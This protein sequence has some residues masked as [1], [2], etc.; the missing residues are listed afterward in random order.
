MGISKE[1]C[2][3]I[4]VDNTLEIKHFDICSIESIGSGIYFC[5]AVT[6]ANAKEVKKTFNNIQILNVVFDKENELATKASKEGID[7]LTF[8]YK[9][10]ELNVEGYQYVLALKEKIV[11]AQN[12][13]KDLE[14]KYNQAK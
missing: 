6:V 8:D 11:I 7:L 1:F 12:A 9:K 2:S 4:H 13:Y 3:A 5:T 10:N 14:K